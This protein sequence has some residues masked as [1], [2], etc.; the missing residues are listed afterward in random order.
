[1]AQ[2]EVDFGQFLEGDEQCRRA[3]ALAWLGSALAKQEGCRTAARH[4]LAG[5]V[6][7]APNDPYH[8]TAFVELDAMATGTDEHLDLLAP[9]LRQAAGRCEEHIR[10]SIEV[11]RAWLTLAKIRLLLGDEDGAMDALCLGAR[12]A[13]TE[14]PLEDFQHSLARL[15]DALDKPRPDKPRSSVALLDLCAQLLAQAKAWPTA[16]NR[17]AFEWLQPVE[18]RF[19]FLPGQRVVLLAG[20]T[21]TEDAV[22]WPAY[23]KHLRAA[24]SGYEGYVLTGGTTAGLCGL[25]ARVARD[26]NGVGQAKIE[27]VGYVP[28]DL[29]SGAAAES[30]FP[31]FVRT[32]G[33]CD[34]S[35]QEPLQMWADLLASG[36]APQDV[37]LLCL[38]GGAV[39]AAELALAWALG[40]RSSVL[41]DGSTAAGRFASVLEWAGDLAGRGSLVPDDAAALAAWF[42]FELPIDASMWEAAGQAVHE[43]YVTSQHKKARQP[44]L[45]PWAHLRDDFKHSNRHQAACS[46][47]ILRRAGFLVERTA[48]KT[49]EIPLPK[50]TVEE[51]EP[52]AE[53][54]HGRWLVERLNAGWRYGKKK[55]EACRLSPWLVAWRDLREDIRDYDREA[56]RAWPKILAGAGWIVRHP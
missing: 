49:E 15:K 39:S 54:E 1:M 6:Q 4:C 24:L 43:A 20:S 3:T 36:V 26:L 50:F 16:T 53:A 25:V 7:L 47:G 48:L 34:F 46:A 51:V 40:A 28:E 29:P 33:T 2:P 22:R 9:S 11:T 21:N 45:L 23:E 5:A 44:N 12:C 56:V 38:G 55:D 31:N 18:K 32:K 52:M 17:S 37:S 19:E 41:A 10:A 14:L 35:V 30:G 42:V 27:L 13:E 8:F